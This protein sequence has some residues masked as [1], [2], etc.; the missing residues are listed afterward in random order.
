[1]EQLGNPGW[2]PI[3]FSSAEGIKYYF[4]AMVRLS[5]DTI[6]G[7]YYF[8]QMLFHLSYAGEENRFLTSCTIRQKEFVARFLAHM[9][10]AYP[11]EIEENL[12]ADEALSTYELWSKA[13]GA[14]KREK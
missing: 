8:D 11:E 7:D 4:P 1:M 10:S 13:Q 3:C 9:I 2:D 6:H 5:I 12:S 14:K